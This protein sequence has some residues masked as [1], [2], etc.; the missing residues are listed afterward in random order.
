MTWQQRAVRLVHPLRIVLWALMA[1]MVVWA[2]LALISR[3]N[4]PVAPLLFTG[5]VFFLQ[6]GLAELDPVAQ[7]RRKQKEK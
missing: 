1:A 2:V 7:S 3:R 5:A 6:L 4:D